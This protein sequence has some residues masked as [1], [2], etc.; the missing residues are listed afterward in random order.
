M[1]APGLL[2][3]S[4]KSLFPRANSA[5][6]LKPVYGSTYPYRREKYVC[7]S[8]P[9]IP[10]LMPGSRLGA[11]GFVGST[12]CG[13]LVGAFALHACSGFPTA[14]WALT[15]RSQVGFDSSRCWLKMAQSSPALMKST[16]LRVGLLK[17]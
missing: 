2:F 5:R 10:R 12:H 8:T 13:V 3:V 7:A 15:P 4:P 6:M 9:S 16:P 1:S 14:M 11:N 17:G